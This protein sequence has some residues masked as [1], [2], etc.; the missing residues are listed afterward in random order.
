MQP[1]PQQQRSR[2]A[3]EALGGATVAELLQPAVPK[4][5]IETAL[6]EV[7]SYLYFT[8]CAEAI[9]GASVDKSLWLGRMVAVAMA[10]VK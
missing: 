10:E 7:G 6:M 1:G 2:L 3:S 9:K 8:P 5:A 4:A